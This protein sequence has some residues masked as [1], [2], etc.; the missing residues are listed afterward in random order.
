MPAHPLCWRPVPTFGDHAC[1]ATYAQRG[2]RHARQ[3][4]LA[5]GC[6][7]RKGRLVHA[8]ALA[9]PL[10][11]AGSGG[12]GKQLHAAG[13]GAHAEEMGQEAAMALYP[14]PANAIALVTS[15]GFAT[16]SSTRRSG[17]TA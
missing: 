13:K 9:A 10:E 17:P 6:Q 16:R 15:G 2:S 11:K 12:S 14:K 1:G 5:R 7:T 8:L 3:P 4:R